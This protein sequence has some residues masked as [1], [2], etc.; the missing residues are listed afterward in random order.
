[1]YFRLLLLFTVFL[2]FQVNAESTRTWSK[3]KESEIRKK[4]THEQYTVTQYGGTETPFHN[5]YWDNKEEGIYVDIVSGEPLF[6]SKDKYQSGTGW[7]SFTRPLVDNHIKEKP[8]CDAAYFEL[9]TILLMTK[10]IDLASDNLE[11]AYLIER[12]NQWYTLAYLNALGASED[13]QT[14]IEILKEKKKK[15]PDEAEWEYQLATVYFTKGKA[16]KSIRVLNRI[17]K[18]KGFSEKITLLKA[19]IYES[20]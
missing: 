12:D 19:S 3:P 9:G 16:G 2:S 1:M 17:E 13:Y 18:N 15:D 11:K 20:Q 4:L 7:P 5:A 6:S 14:I 10:Q 8:D